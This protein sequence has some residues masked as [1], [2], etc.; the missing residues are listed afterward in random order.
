M[1]FLFLP[2][3]LRFYQDIAANRYTSEYR[4][5]LEVSDA[6]KQETRHLGGFW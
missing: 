1:R 2:S 5:S 3:S 6:L 4:D